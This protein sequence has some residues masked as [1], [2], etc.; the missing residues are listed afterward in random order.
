GVAVGPDKRLYVCNSN[1]ILVF[2]PGSTGDVPPV[3][4]ISGPNTGIGICYRLAVDNSKIYIT[5]Y[6]GDEIRLFAKSSNGDVSPLAVIKGTSTRLHNPAGIAVDS[7][8]KM[9]V[10]NYDSN[11]VTVF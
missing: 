8:G 5:G 4:K 9:F 7:G 2:A 10:T 1:S 11:S 3:G 6:S